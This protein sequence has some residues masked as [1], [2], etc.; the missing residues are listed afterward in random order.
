MA[1]TLPRVDEPFPIF[2]LAGRYLLYDVNAITY[3]RREYLI[4]GVLIGGLPQAPQ[5]N[6][7]LGIPSELMPEEA[8]LLVEKGVAYIVDDVANHKRGFLGTGG[9]GLSAEER[10]A[11][12]QA[13]RRQGS[14]AARDVSKKSETRKKTAL[15]Q[16]L[17]AEN[18]NDIPEV[19]LKPTASRTKKAVAAKAEEEKPEAA[20]QDED[21]LLFASPANSFPTRPSRS[22]ATSSASSFAG[23]EPYA[24]TPTTS[25]PP[26]TAHPTVP[27]MPL[28]EVPPSYPLF[29]HMHEKF[30]FMTPGLRFGCQYTA[31]P[32]DPL[33][34]HS[35]FLCNGMDWDREFD[36]LDL[37]GGGR[38]GTGVKK[39]YL[40]GG[41][42]PAGEGKDAEGSN[43]RTFCIEWG[44]M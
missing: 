5:Q 21:E 32:G 36:L 30:Y 13:L 25:Y 12:M 20:A 22:R 44:G 38:L 23:P 42:E 31:Y 4:G 40:I 10:K 15:K 8:R 39:G 9:G 41:E 3:I 27:S 11:F 7:F 35:H 1:S 34:F 29:K 37:V 17:G 2:T 33:R 26:L 18:W 24:I 14:Q 16:K 19:M 28:P 6:V 43:V